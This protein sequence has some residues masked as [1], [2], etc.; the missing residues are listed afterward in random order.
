MS[1]SVVGF[2]RLATRENVDESGSVVMTRSGSA[3]FV[4]SGVISARFRTRRIQ[5][6]RRHQDSV[7][8]LN[9]MNR[10]HPTCRSDRKL[11]SEQVGPPSH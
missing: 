9:S 4:P 3:V 8:E 2:S 6:C 11:K 10:T 7:S 5:I 1:R